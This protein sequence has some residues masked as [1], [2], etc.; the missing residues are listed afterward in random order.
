M[1]RDFA[2]STQL[3]L[4]FAISIFLL[5]AIGYFIDKKAATMPLF[6]CIF[7]ALGFAAGLYRIIKNN[8]AKK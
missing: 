5:G 2:E 8:K 3:G 4:E 6:T 7:G 1:K